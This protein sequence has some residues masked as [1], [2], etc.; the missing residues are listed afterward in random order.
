MPNVDFLR[1]QIIFLVA[2][3]ATALPSAACSQA[4]N[5]RGAELVGAIADRRSEDPIPSARVSVVRSSDGVSVWSGVSDED[6]RFRTPAIPLGD[7]RLHVEAPPF[8]T[9][10]EPVTLS[11]AG[12][13]DLR[14]ELVGV[15]YQLGPIVVVA[16][17]STRLQRE[18]FYDRQRQGLGSFVT[19][20]DIEA[21]KPFRTSDLLRQIPGL[22]VQ[23]VG[24]GRGG[25]Q[26][27]MARDAG[28]TPLIVVDRALAELGG[29]LG[30]VNERFDPEDLEG[31]EIFG[32]ASVPAEYTSI[33]NCGVVMFWT[34][35]AGTSA[36]GAWFPSWKKLLVVGSL[37]G[38]AILA[39]R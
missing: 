35:D 3:S 2:V 36:S 30:G 23:D 15:D 6:G 9:L 33:T 5:G 19:R 26:I 31:I 27:S 32:G 20:A 28:C 18:G 8:V 16:R 25:T 21:T 17:R 38:L 12:V 34:R 7:Y 24:G 37:V 11:E 13:V 4:P 22:R 29:P 39:T 14:V 10:T 1:W